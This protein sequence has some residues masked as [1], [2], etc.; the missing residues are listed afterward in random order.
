M[1]LDSKIEISLSRASV[2]FPELMLLSFPLEGGKIY[3]L[4]SKMSLCSL[5]HILR[6]FS[7][8]FLVTV[9]IFLLYLNWKLFRTR[10]VL[11]I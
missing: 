2:Y 7:L 11:Y 3:L 8:I 6:N 9:C 4:F 1:V 5:L 10:I